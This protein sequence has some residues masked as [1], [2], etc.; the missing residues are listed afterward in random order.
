MFVAIHA[1]IALLFE[2]VDVVHKTQN[3]GCSAADI[4]YYLRK[5]NV[6]ILAAVDEN[7]QQHNLN[8]R[9]LQLSG[10]ISDMHRCLVVEILLQV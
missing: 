10:G 2:N 3:L 8:G 7:R 9:K 6:I 1:D 5:E 4:F